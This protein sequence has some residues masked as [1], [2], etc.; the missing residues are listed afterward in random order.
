M[1]R[2]IRQNILDVKPY[3]PGKPIEEVQR[4]LGLKNVIK[5]ASNENCF[6]PSP[7]AVAAMRASLRNVHRYPDASCFYLKQRLAR[8]FGIGE[9]M[10]T[11]G[12]GSDEVI[13]LAIRTL[14]SEREE[15]IIARPT[16]LIYEIAS[17][18][19]NATIRF[20]P[21]TK[22]FKHDLKAMK[23]AITPATKMVFIAN[24]DNPTGTYVTKAELDEFFEGLPGNVIVF[25]DEAYFEFADF[26]FKD[27]PNGID[28]LNRPNVIV[29]RST[30]TDT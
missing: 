7:K 23:K 5:M 13:V 1:K 18:L 4:E 17:Q 3:V 2:L 14:V 16:F 28:Y 22:E 15:V 20:I 24:P 11:L 27:Y 21:S 10:I 9:N 19:S 26:S 6:G 30:P 29:S 12:N 25:L 8:M